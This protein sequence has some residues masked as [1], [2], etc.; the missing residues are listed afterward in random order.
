LQ[1]CTVRQDNG[2]VNNN[3]SY[4]EKEYVQASSEAPTVGRSRGL[5]PASLLATSASTACIM[6]L[7][8]T[9]QLQQWQMDSSGALMPLL[10]GT[11][12][13][14]SCWQVP[15]PASRPTAVVST[16]HAPFT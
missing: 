8:R 9:H 1:R 7:H 16:M 12:L 14:C 4:L 3:A 10:A 5:P 6:W 11:G 13:L 2:R 15:L